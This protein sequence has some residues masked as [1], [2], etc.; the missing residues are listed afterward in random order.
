MSAE[1][2]A[3]APA[4]FAAHWP[5]TI[6]IIVCTLAWGT[7]WFAI[8]LQ[9]GV[10]DPV[11]SIVYRFAIASALLC[12]WCLARREPLTLTARQHVTALGLGLFNFTLN[13]TFVYWAEERVTSAVVAVSFAALAFVN[14]G[15]FRLVFGQRANGLAWGAALLGVAGVALMSWQEIARTDMDARAIE[16]VALALVAVLAASAANL[17]AR[18]AELLQTPV[19]PLTAWAMFYGTLCLAAYALAV[20]KRWTFEP[21]LA[22]VGSLLHLSIVGS[23]VAFLLYYG[24]ARRRGYTLAS[25]ISALTPPVAMLVS[26]VFEHKSW[27]PLALAGVGLVLLGQAVLLRGKRGA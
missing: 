21:S 12:I 23:V 11:I 14:L 26:A 13:Y 25:Y 22:Y 4:R 2:S 15:M 3:E 7:T 17:W 24:L 18:R 1:P 6:A 27:G 19:A 8:T 5:D 10:V 20:G 16:G 9:F